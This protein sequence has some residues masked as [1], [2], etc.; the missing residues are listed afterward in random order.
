MLKEEPRQRAISE[1]VNGV[2]EMSKV[3]YLLPKE[4]L[5]QE[6]NV[7]QLCCAHGKFLSIS[8]LVFQ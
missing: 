4:E 5:Y 6:L 1:G 7:G 2:Q 8:P 3:Q